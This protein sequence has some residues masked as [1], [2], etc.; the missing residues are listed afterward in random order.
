MH[1]DS[2][3]LGENKEMLVEKMDSTVF[4]EWQYFK[5]GEKLGDMFFAAGG[6]RP[7]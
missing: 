3:K 1:V 6:Q 5:L 7:R 2:D 4:A